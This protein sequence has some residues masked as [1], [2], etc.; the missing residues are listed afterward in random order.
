MRV[1]SSEYTM[2]GVWI[3]TGCFK[4]TKASP[5]WYCLQELET[6]PMLVLCR[7]N[8]IIIYSLAPGTEVLYSEANVEIIN[9][10]MGGDE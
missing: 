10:V 4:L 6:V 3:S 9:S 1:F 5:L 8:K 2:D 7:D